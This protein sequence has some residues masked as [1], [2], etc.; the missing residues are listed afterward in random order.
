MTLKLIDGEFLKEFSGLVH[1]YHDRM[2]A[3]DSLSDPAVLLLSVYL[4]E[5]KNKKSGA[6]Y[7]QTKELFTLLGRKYP[8]FRVTVHNAKKN[9]LIDSEG[10]TLF[11]LI[12]GLKEIR[13]ILGQVGKSPIHIIKSGQ[14]FTAVRLF[15]E[16][17]LSEIKSAEIFLC[18]SYISHS[19]LFPF[20]AL[21][22]KITL[23]RILTSN[24]YDSEK[25]DEY[26]KKM[27]REMGIIIE[28][29]NSKKI[30]ERFMICGDRCWFIG[31][32]I[33]DLGNK[34]AVIREI[35]EVTSSMKNLFL[36]R[37]DEA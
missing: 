35:S 13:K 8:N 18:D 16:F 37:W 30:H 12:K 10:K 23:L 4:L 28:V 19:T 33:K 1:Q 34:D 6:E 20:S 25:F 9:G 29:K 24:V 32:S 21:R 31:S 26:K 11:L 15:E 7:D 22:G 14:N 27:G 3:D 5:K 17:L 2:L 36:D